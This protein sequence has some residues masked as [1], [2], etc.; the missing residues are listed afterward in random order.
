MK[1]QDYYDESAL[2]NVMKTNA[3]V[4]GQLDAGKRSNPFQTIQTAQSQDNLNQL[5][6]NN[7]G[8]MISA[9]TLN[10]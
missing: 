3:R 2:D 1:I 10:R 7:Q 5:Y 8:N 9:K 4:L 6:R